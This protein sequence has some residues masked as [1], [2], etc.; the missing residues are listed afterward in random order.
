MNIMRKYLNKMIF[1]SI[2]F[3]SFGFSDEFSD[4]PYGTGYFDT[5][6]PFIVPDLNVSLQ[7]DVNLDDIIKLWYKT[8]R[9]HIDECKEKKLYK[10]NAN[11]EKVIDY[12]HIAIVN[13]LKLIFCPKSVQNKIFTTVQKLLDN[14]KLQLKQD[15]LIDLSEDGLKQDAKL[16]E[17]Y[18]KKVLNLLEEYD[19]VYKI[20]ADNYSILKV[21]EEIKRSG[22]AKKGIVLPYFNTLDHKESE[23]VKSSEKNFKEF[24][25]EATS[26]EALSA[27][28]VGGTM[29]VAM[30]SAGTVFSELT[31]RQT[32]IS[33]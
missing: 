2:F 32:S 21:M 27:F 14:E 5:A 4:G 3:I 16:K 18:D 29:G 20:T 24:I 1:I 33:L 11:L 31:S 15:N 28:H 19:W 17:W 23:T 9:G 13:E 10:R 25:K 22:Y 6:G 7:G 30:G 12:K 26:P 8:Q